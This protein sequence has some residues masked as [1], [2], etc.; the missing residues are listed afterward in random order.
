VV[1]VGG[2]TK[3]PLF[4]GVCRALDIPFVVMA[5]HDVRDIDP[6][7]SEKRRQSENRRNAKHES[8]NG[9]ISGAADD[10]QIF[11]MRPDFEAEVGLPREDSE[12]LDRALALFREAGADDIAATLADTIRATVER[13]Q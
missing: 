1:E 10:S 9:C 6:G 8:W 4:A 12:K 11:W 13:L 2:K 5:D 7:W 3:L